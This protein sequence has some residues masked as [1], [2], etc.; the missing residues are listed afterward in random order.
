MKMHVAQRRIGLLAF[1]AVEAIHCMELTRVGSA[2]HLGEVTGS[3]EGTGMMLRNSEKLSIT[4]VEGAHPYPATDLHY[5]N[6]PEHLLGTHPDNLADSMENIDEQ[7]ELTQQS[8]ES[9]QKR[10]SNAVGPDGSLSPHNQLGSQLERSAGNLKSIHEDILKRSG[11]QDAMDNKDLVTRLR[12][13]I[14]EM[15]E[16]R[17][18]MQEVLKPKANAELRYQAHVLHKLIFQT[19]DFMQEKKLISPELLKE[20]FE[21][22]KMLESLAG[23]LMLSSNPQGNVRNLVLDH[24]KLGA[25]KNLQANI[26]GLPTDTAALRKLFTK[27]MNPGPAQ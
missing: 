22:P 13:I 18:N 21:E 9:L 4:D 7:F 19:I 16:F 23:H 14:D 24:S 6:H 8:L 11:F 10:M 15:P 3:S 12:G 5:M 25:S 17:T 20:F 2:A 27:F 26:D 1:L